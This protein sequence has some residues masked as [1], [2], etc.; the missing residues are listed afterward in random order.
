[1]YVYLCVE[2]VDNV[3][4]RFRVRARS[5]AR[6]HTMSF[7]NILVCLWAQ[8][9]VCRPHTHIHTF[10]L[11]YICGVCLCVHACVR[12]SAAGSIAFTV[13]RVLSYSRSGF[14]F[15]LARNSLARQAGT[16]SIFIYSALRVC[17]YHV[18]NVFVRRN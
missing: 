10:R 4:T 15:E 17:V 16:E 8:S 7:V 9:T 3:N 14:P 5:Y 1:M 6:A 18:P 13:W 2:G 12:P 11:T